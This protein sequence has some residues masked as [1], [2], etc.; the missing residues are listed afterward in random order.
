MLTIKNVSYCYAGRNIPTLKN[1]SI[2]INKRE[3]ILIAGRT[4]CGKSTLI[5]VINGLLLGKGGGQ[6][7][8][9]V[10]SKGFNILTLTPEEMGLLVGTVYQSPDD[11]LFAMEQYLS[12]FQMVHFLN[13]F[14]LKAPYKLLIFHK[15]VSI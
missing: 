8:G 5:K 15:M 1:I 2:D 10:T 3:M 7:S 13:V 14:P 11:Q 6:F 9:E 12:S 4:G